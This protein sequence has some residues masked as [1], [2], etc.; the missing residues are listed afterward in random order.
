MSAKLS[1]EDGGTPTLA[2][3]PRPNVVPWWALP[4]ATDLAQYVHELTLGSGLD[5]DEL[6]DAEETD[7]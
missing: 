4:F 6:A 3:D 7:Q 2:R 5:E 1:W